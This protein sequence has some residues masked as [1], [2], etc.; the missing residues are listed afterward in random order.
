[1]GEHGGE[2]LRELFS[3]ERMSKEQSVLVETFFGSTIQ[4]LYQERRCI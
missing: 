3:E 1:M 4:I 2:E